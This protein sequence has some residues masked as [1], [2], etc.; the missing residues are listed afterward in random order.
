MFQVV[1]IGN[2]SVKYVFASVGDAMQACQRLN[3]ALRA[4]VYMVAQ[5]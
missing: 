5:R 3:E 4:N 2:G 1:R